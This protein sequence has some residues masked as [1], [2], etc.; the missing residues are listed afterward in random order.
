MHLMKNANKVHIDTRLKD[1]L[2]P[3]ISMTGLSSEVSCT[4]EGGNSEAT[5]LGSR[6]AC[7]GPTKMKMSE[8]TREYRSE[9][10]PGP[11]ILGRGSLGADVALV[12]LDYQSVATRTKNEKPAEHCHSCY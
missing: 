11:K 9:S 5:Q 3:L 2:T 4:L 7:K 8:K 1:D 6:P 12:L 10:G